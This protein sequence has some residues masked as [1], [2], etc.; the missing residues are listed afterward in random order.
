MIVITVE[1]WPKG[2]KK[3]K[4]EIAKATITNDGKGNHIIGN[5]KYKIWE[6]GK[7]IGE[8]R[9]KGFYRVLGVWNLFFRVLRKTLKGSFKATKKL[10]KEKTHEEF[11]REMIDLYKSG[12]FDLNWEET[13]D[14]G[15][16]YRSSD[17]KD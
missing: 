15:R 4:Y 10:L 6:Y 7:I 17:R 11:E 16:I 3:N 12:Y 8:G 5:Y 14:D 13:L 9:L 2:Y 1:M